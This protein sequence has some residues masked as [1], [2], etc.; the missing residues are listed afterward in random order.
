MDKIACFEGGGAAH[1]CPNEDAKAGDAE[2]HS[3]SDAN[4]VQVIREGY[5]SG[6]GQQNERPCVGNATRLRSHRSFRSRHI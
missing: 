4:P 1:G 3:K 6:R 5:C 2:A